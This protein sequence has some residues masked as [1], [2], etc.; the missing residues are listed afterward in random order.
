MIMIKRVLST[1]TAV[2]ILAGIVGLAAAG[3]GAANGAVSDE[4]SQEIAQASNGNEQS[5]LSQ[6]SLALAR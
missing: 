3:T 4:I 6:I 1:A 2:A 5:P